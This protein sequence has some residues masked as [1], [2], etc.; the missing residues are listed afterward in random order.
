M[1]STI[2]LGNLEK[3]IKRTCVFAKRVGQMGYKVLVFRRCNEVDFWYKMWSLELSEASCY[4][5]R[6][7]AEKRERD[8]QSHYIEVS[9][10]K[11]YAIDYDSIVN[12]TEHF[13]PFWQ[14]CFWLFLAMKLPKSYLM[15]CLF[16][17]LSCS[18]CLANGKT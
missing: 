6:V 15:V 3:E 5:C 9:S 12:I 16:L 1:S 14:L 11:Q 4:I 18:S 17:F 2:S 13:I 8:N 10:L 7:N